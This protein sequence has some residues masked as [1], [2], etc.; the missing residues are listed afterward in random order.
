MFIP[1]SYGPRYVKKEDVLY[2][3]QS[4]QKIIT[5]AYVVAG[6]IPVFMSFLVLPD[7]VETYQSL[8]VTPSV[9]VNVTPVISV[10]FALLGI[11]FAY[12][13]TT[14]NIKP[15]IQKKIK[16]YKKNDMINYDKTVLSGTRTKHMLAFLVVAGLLGFLLF[17]WPIFT[18]TSS[19]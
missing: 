9:V 2:Y 18:L 16:K 3:T 12:Q 6:L 13:N 17:I 11:F 15:I 7:I 19:I 14:I 4:Q 5:V 1:I 10:I 8:N